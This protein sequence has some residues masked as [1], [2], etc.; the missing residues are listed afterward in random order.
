MDNRPTGESRE[1]LGR[2]V[3]RGLYFSFFLKTKSVYLFTFL[4]VYFFL[5]LTGYFFR[6]Q[7]IIN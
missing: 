2:D 7:G 5:L 3:R 1:L 4:P 6:A